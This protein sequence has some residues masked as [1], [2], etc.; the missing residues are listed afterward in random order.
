M[1][2]FSHE[3]TGRNDPCP[4]GSGKKYKHCCLSNSAI[5]FP[6][7]NRSDTPW[8]RQRDAS[9][10]LTAQLQRHLERDMPELGDFVLDAWMEFN[11]DEDYIINNY[12]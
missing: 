6:G 4:C 8:N 9:D 3:K 10:N 5:A 1:H 12:K 7:P 2:S 11:Q